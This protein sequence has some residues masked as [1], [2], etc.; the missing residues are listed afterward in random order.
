MSIRQDGEE[1][2]DWD[3]FWGSGKV[4]DYLRYRNCR[5]E[6]GEAEVEETYYGNGN[7]KFLEERERF[8]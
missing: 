8:M 6:S 1:T 3:R 5:Q 7:R 4:E 2:R